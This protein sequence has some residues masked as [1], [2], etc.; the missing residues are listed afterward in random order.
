MSSI[1]ERQD[2]K[3]AKALPDRRES[4]TVYRWILIALFGVAIIGLPV[5]GSFYNIFAEPPYVGP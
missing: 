2:S 5:A 4:R 1:A 3:I